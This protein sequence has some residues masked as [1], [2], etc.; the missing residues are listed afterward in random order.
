MSQKPEYYS[1]LGIAKGASEEE[2]KKAYTKAAMRN[3][4]DRMHGK[5]D[6]E[7]EAAKLKF[8]EIEEAYSVLT[9]EKKRTTYDN[10]GHDGLERMAAGQSA[11]TGRSYSDLAG[12]GAKRTV[13][14]DDAFS[15]FDRGGDTPDAIPTDGQRA[16]RA[17]AA[18][19][20]RKAREERRGSGNGA[21]S[22]ISGLSVNIP[23]ADPVGRPAP[24]PKPAPAP[25]RETPK[26]AAKK[27]G[28][29]FDFD[30]ASRD[31][32]ATQDKI[33][34]VARGGFAEVPLDTLERFR[35]NVQ[36]MLNVIDA[37]IARAKRGGP[38]P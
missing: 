11:G 23:P 16:D 6:A 8:Q 26:P 28:S 10:Y 35:D 24:T 32:R 22:I 19:A 31:M 33:S 14:P 38:R 7:K 13:N 20:R 37:A 3:H 25:A 5:S 2:I 15:Y 21:G 12:P 27:T 29:G 17:A 30:G 34:T 9:D 1:V 4:P 36:D 18:E